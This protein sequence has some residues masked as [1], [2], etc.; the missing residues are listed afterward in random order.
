MHRPKRR[1]KEM[2]SLSTVTKVGV[3][4]SGLMGSGIAQVVAS[5]NIPVVF[6]DVSEKS[7]ER[8]FDSIKKNLER[9]VQKGK[10][11]EDSKNEVISLISTTSNVQD[12]ADVDYTFE[13]IIE[14]MQIKKDLYTKLDSICKPSCIFATNTSGLSITEIAAATNR[15]DKFIG[16]HF[17]N[18]VPA[19]KLLE[20]IRAYNTSEETYQTTMEL[21]T[22]IGKELITVEESPLFC[23]NRILIP[24]L[25]E[26]MYVLME[27]IATKEDI[28]KG[29]VLGV[30]HPMGPLA[31]AD[32][33]GLDTLLSIFRTLF[34]ETGDS[35]YR[36]CPLL[37]KLV[38]AGHYGR[39][40]GRGFY[41]YS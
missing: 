29:M 5:A 19:M 41:T 1:F 15:S 11:T 37:V 38:R 21:G 9:E 16:A 27:G 18:P 33:I 31:L 35:K 20:V 13:A 39:K 4:G 3:I 40:N 36:P 23:V 24:M 7:V 8:G 30:N 26:A 14:N 10:R 2:E 28:D 25:N 17:F 34:E 6:Y 22:R 12:L 32:L